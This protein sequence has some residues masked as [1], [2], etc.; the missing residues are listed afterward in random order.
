MKKFPPD[1]F[2]G[3]TLPG[4]VME[5][6]DPLTI[7]PGESKEWPAFVLVVKGKER[8]WVP[9]RYLNGR[10]GKVTATRRY[11]TTTLSPQE[12][13]ILTVIEEDT[14]SGWLWCKD[15]KGNIGWFAAD[16]VAALPQ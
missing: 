10:K 6:G 11:D 12:G 9:R 13:E 8:G 16:H 4:M 2:D 3:L 7:L 14:E 1:F 5:P 15:R